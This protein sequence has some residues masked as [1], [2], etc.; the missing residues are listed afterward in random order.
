M[1]ELNMNGKRLSDNDIVVLISKDSVQ[2]LTEVKFFTDDGE[3]A[4]DDITATIDIKINII[5]DENIRQ[6]VDAYKTSLNTQP[7]K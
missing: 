6:K 3:V 4:I 2:D 1:L 7:C 5:C